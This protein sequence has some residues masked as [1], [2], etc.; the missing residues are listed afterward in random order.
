MNPQTIVTSVVLVLALTGLDGLVMLAVRLRGTVIPDWLAR[1]HGFM[2]PAA[3]ALSLSAAV[4][5]ELP[6]IAWGALLLLGLAG[7]GG[8]CTSP[9][10]RVARFCPSV[11]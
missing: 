6:A 3:L 4:F 8:I 2:A 10:R 9:S 11:G 1:A 5:I 7:A